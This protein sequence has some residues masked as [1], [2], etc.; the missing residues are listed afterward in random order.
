[1]STRVI[2]ILEAIYPEML[3]RSEVSEAAGMLLN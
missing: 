2:E 1:M 3:G